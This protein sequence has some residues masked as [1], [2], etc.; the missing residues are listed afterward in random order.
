MG[1]EFDALADLNFFVKDTFDPSAPQ[2]R[3]GTDRQRPI[4]EAYA[5]LAAAG[6]ACLYDSGLRDREASLWHEA[7]VATFRMLTYCSTTDP[8]PTT[9]Q[10]LAT[11]VDERYAQWGDPGCKS[12]CTMP[13]PLRRSARMLK[14]PCCVHAAP[15]A[16]PRPSAR[17]ERGSRR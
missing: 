13:S 16:L 11:H 6:M 5:S 15:P 9:K 17:W 1:V 2:A 7:S 10:V 4:K 14:L 3:A 8:Y 12:E